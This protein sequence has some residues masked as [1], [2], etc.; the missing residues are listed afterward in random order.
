M[1]IIEH[2]CNSPEEFIA[3]D[4][5]LLARAEKGEISETLR[6]WESKD[7]FVVLGRACKMREDCFEEHLP[8][9]GIK[10]VRRTSGGGTVLQG[11]G[12][13]NYS[14]ILAY[15]SSADY[16]NIDSSYRKILGAISGLLCEHGLETKVLPL[17]DITLGGRKISGNAQ[18]RK[19]KFFLH[20]GTFL[21]GFDLK[22]ISLYLKHPS[23]E[24]EYRLRRAH[25]EFLENLPITRETIKDILVKVFMPY[26]TRELLGEEEKE[27]EEL[28][29]SKYSDPAWNLEF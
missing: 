5:V 14:A 4:E 24:P 1:E 7:H 25:E 2:E 17:S 21:L 16:R 28:T 8:K 27:T 13:F 11:P 10:I 20:H 15:E 9:D 29:K 3:L 18:A 19:R 6:F 26:G 22:K 12:C 23:V